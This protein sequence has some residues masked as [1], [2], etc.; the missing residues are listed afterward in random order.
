MKS[1]KEKVEDRLVKQDQSLQI[2]HMLCRLRPLYN[3]LNK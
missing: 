2:V 3:D 1:L